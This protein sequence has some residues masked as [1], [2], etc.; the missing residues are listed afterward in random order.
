MNS[1]KTG[2]PVAAVISVAML[3]AHAAAI[4][5]VNSQDADVNQ[6]GI[7]DILD[8]IQV[9]SSINVLCEGECPTDVDG[10][11]TTNVTDLRQVVMFW[12]EMVSHDEPEIDDTDSP[13]EPQEPADPVYAGP[14]PIVLDGVYYDANSRHVSRAQLGVAL[15]QGWRTR[16]QNQQDGIDV[17]PYAYGGG[18]DYNADML[19]TS[20]DL[21]SFEAWLDE[22]VPEDYTGPVVLDME[23][24]WWAQMSVASTAEMED[25]MDFYIQGIEYAKVMR[26]NAKFGYWGLPK[27]H[28]T[29]DHY[30]GP[31]MARLLQASGAIFPDSYE[32]N[33]DYNDS[34]RL[35]RHVER[36]IELVQGEVPVYVQMCP[37]FRDEETG[38]WR[39]YFHDEEFLRDQG[40]A[41]LDAR[42]VDASGRTH[43]VAGIAIWDC[44]NYAKLYHDDWSSLNDDE[45]IELWDEIDFIH[46]DLYRSLK[47]LSTEYA[48]AGAPEAPAKQLTPVSTR[49]SRQSKKPIVKKNPVGKPR[50]SKASSSGLGSGRR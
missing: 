46:A 21:A 28:M 26:P 20:E 24:A 33:P 29:T 38:Q 11:G 35:R 9:V 22:N 6:D 25:I 36:C 23:G 3:G 5:Q 1:L 42:W 32:T 19:Y 50:A 7:I 34:V 41:S 44:Y 47:D 43:R 10:D 39:Y 30:T 40:E 15:D 49:S 12:G 27:K 16:S 13:E 4:G 2:A 18:V 8:L 37:R 48:V 45:I 31:S 17:L 14:N